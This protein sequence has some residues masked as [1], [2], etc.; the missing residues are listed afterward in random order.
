MARLIDVAKAAGVSR[1][2][3]SAVFNKPDLV[4]PKLRRRVEA[5]ARELGYA[6]PDPKGRLLR[7]G[8]FNAIGLVAPGRLTVV[9]SLRNPVFQLFVLGV[10]EVCDEVGADLVITSDAARDGRSVRTALVDGFVFASVDQIA[11]VEPARLRRL[12]FVVVD[13]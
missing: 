4:R 12:S 9:E 11:E 2:T 3:A 13:V 1:S 8:R 10:A 7:A 6:G 5:A